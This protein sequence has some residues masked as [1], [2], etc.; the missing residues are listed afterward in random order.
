MKYLIRQIKY[1][2]D[3]ITLQKLELIGFIY[4]VEYNLFYNKNNFR[5]GYHTLYKKYELFYGGYKNKIGFFESFTLL[6]TTICDYLE[7][8]KYKLQI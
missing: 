3:K 7:R 5:I 8:E 4:D 2:R 1:E 6:E